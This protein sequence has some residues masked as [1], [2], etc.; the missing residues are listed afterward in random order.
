MRIDTLEAYSVSP[1]ILRIWTTSVGSELLPVQEKAIKEFGLFSDR[2]LIVFSPTSSGKTFVGEMAAVKAARA[3]TKV[4]YLVPQ[5]ALADEKYEEFRNRYAGADI[6]VV[7]SSRD[8]REFDTDIENGRFQIAIVVVEKLQSLLISKPQLMNTVGLVVVDELQLITDEMRGASLEL[9]L[10]QLKLSHPVRIVGLSAVLGRAQSLADWLEAKLLIDTNRPVELR[11]GVLCKGSFTYVEHNSH[12]SGSEE[13]VDTQSDRR[14]ELILDAARFLVERDE[15]VLIFVPDRASTLGFAKALAERIR[16]PALDTALDELREQEDTHARDALFE[17]LSSSIAF[18]NSDLSTEER[19]LV[20]RHFRAGAIR[21]LFSTSTLAMGMNLPVKNVILDERK[22]KHFR[23]YRRWG[24]HDISKSEYE[25]MSGRAGRLSL[26]KDFG[27]SILITDSK[28][29][30]DVWLDHYVNAGFDDIVPTLRETPLENHVVNLVAGG[31]AQSRET[32]ERLLLSSFT[33]SVHWMQQMSREEF[34]ESLDA[35]IRVCT[36]AELVKKDGSNLSITNLG[37]ACAAKG[38]DVPTAV[39]FARWAHDARTAA[40]SEVEVLT[41]VSMAPGGDGVYVN[42]RA[43]EAGR[44]DCREEVRRRA[45]QAGV[46]DRPIFQDFGIEWQRVTYET[47]KALKKVLFLHDWLNELPI[48]EIE[49]RYF[50]WAGALRRVGEEYGWLVEALAAIAKACGWRDNRCRELDEISRRLTFGVRSDALSIAQLRVHGLGRTRIRSLIDA[51]FATEEELQQAD[52]E[53]VRKAINHKG[54]FKAL[55]AHVH[56]EEPTYTLGDHTH[57]SGIAEARATY[58]GQSTSAGRRLHFCGKTRK[59]RYLLKINEREEW[60]TMQPFRTLW[61][62]AVG[63]LEGKVDGVHTSE[64][65]PGDV[66]RALSRVRKVLAKH[67][68]VE[69][70]LENDGHGYYRLGVSPQQITWDEGP[71]RD[72]HSVLFDELSSQHEPTVVSATG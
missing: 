10:T 33:G 3:N 61:R 14:E 24:L 17:V 37:K 65:G 7:V 9:L 11:K 52:S 28:F 34:S 69:S 60:V 13:F 45:Q 4:F 22:W 8:R 49:K 56:G 51:G 12:T 31:M 36:D 64:L 59:R 16:M 2:N 70:W 46:G 63:V 43:A 41:V 47:A 38:I 18:H 1:D 48:K 19:R 25:N 5:K 44:F 29:Q 54:A 23:E 42:M 35:A 53:T 71:M 15:Q 50:V 20:E 32:L 55:W 6:K 30:A 66:H 62:L 58:S 57:S 26:V 21:A 68:D 39:A 67:G 72:H 40:I 27:R